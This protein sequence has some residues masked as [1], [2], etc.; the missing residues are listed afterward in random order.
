MA[1]ATESNGKIIAADLQA[2]EPDEPSG[3]K[4]VG[5]REK[6]GFFS[7]YKPN[8]GKPTRLAT[9]AGAA[10]L[11]ALTMWFL[12]YDVSAS[13]PALKKANES[14]NRPWWNITVLVLG[15]AA[16][17]FAWRMVNKPRHAEF[18]IATD[19]EMKKVS[20]T[21]RKQL[22][23]STK[24]VIF[25]MLFIAATLFVIDLLFHYLFY[26]MNVLKFKPMGL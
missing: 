10:L 20:W 22:W 8:Q 15:V 26:L 9:G 25:F 18:L 21:S 1:S 2:P 16:G 11:I 13:F 17:V 6:L 19:S 14:I 12:Y 5:D 7:V 3:G 24:V 23:G 4:P